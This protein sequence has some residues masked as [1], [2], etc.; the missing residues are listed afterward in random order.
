MT[1]KVNNK[2]M[3]QINDL[4]KIYI[5]KHRQRV[6]AL[7]HVNLIL[8]EKGFVFI[9]GKSGSGKSTLLN[10]IGGLDAISDGNIFANGN[11]LKEMSEAQ[12]ADYR[13]SYISFIFQDYHLID[14]LTVYE[15]VALSLNLQNVEDEIKVKNA[16]H[17]V[18]LDGY[19]NRYP[20]ELSGGEKQRVSI[21][22]A[23]VKQPKII[24]AD[25]PTGNLD[26][27]TSL[28]ILKYLKEIAKTS[29]VLIVSHNTSEIEVFAERI[30]SLE[31]GKI[32][33]D[34]S[35]NPSYIDTLEIKENIL[36][37]P[38]RALKDK[39]VT[40]LN[41][42]LQN[43]K[44]HYIKTKTNKYLPTPQIADAEIKIPLKTH[45]FKRNSFFNLLKKF[46]NHK[47]VT[48]GVSSF[49]IA[50]LFIVL[51]VCQSLTNF[52]ADK[53][54]N[55]QMNNYHQD[56]YILKKG[57]EFSQTYNLYDVSEDE[58]MFS[59]ISYKGERYPI[60]PYCLSISNNQL[61]AL[62]YY[63]STDLQDSLFVSQ[64]H[65]MIIVNEAFLADKFGTN[66]KLKLHAGSLNLHK[67]GFIITDYIADC[68]IARGNGFNS[69][70]DLINKPSFF[71]EE[72]V[73]HGYVNAII[74][75]GYHQRYS[76][77]LL[78]IKNATTIED[79]KNITRSEDF[80]SL[81]DEILSSLAIT[82]TINPNFINDEI[83]NT[84]RNFAFMQNALF[85]NRKAQTPNYLIRK[86]SYYDY[87]LKDNEIIMSV[88]WY[89]NFFGTKY[90]INNIENFSP[91]KINFK[92][93]LYSDI[94]RENILIN[95]D[96]YIVGL[97]FKVSDFFCCSEELFKEVFETQF[98]PYATYYSS[99]DNISTFLNLSKKL[100]YTILSS[101]GVSVY[102]MTYVVNM[103]SPVF[104]I[105]NI[106]LIV[107]IVMILALFT[108]KL[109]KDKIHDIGI[110]KALGTKNSKILELFLWQNLFIILS[111]LI[112]FFVGY[113]L[114]ANLCNDL[115]FTSLVNLSN[116]YF[117]FSFKVV[118]F[119]I[120]IYLFDALL[121]LGLAFISL[122]IPYLIIR[123]IKPVKIIKAKE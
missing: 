20:N 101:V 36:I 24:L 98:F 75:T 100:D 30:I 80:I 94:K 86:D 7:D 1:I 9:V 104:T 8:P 33:S 83:N 53:I 87:S 116:K 5:T 10:L 89:N 113:L 40:T 88:S 119:D 90:D 4:S 60:Y 71:L 78:D 107:G 2:D 105:I 31:K 12:L 29:L 112:L 76:A 22:R 64:T 39:E 44:L 45:H 63:P 118:S 49:V 11:S 19:E 51:G 37:I 70:Q 28:N 61:S 32:I 103:F 38:N 43:G 73:P 52:N 109:I 58:D 27:K 41:E 15:N 69:Y 82:Y 111:T 17:Q 34:I 108:V 23:I 3:I 16:L 59:K 56:S 122:F 99:T 93:Y 72:E 13:N 77:L 65:G 57:S 81:N 96:L 120:L 6:K 117:A 47:W 25:E 42:L 74:D 68:F 48:M 26:S 114:L 91:H 55:Q 102:N 92:Q 66:G 62:L 79:Y 35:I 106:C 95:K 50:L 21:A 121:A 67:N 115:I 18:D 84:I 46:A 110:L 85:D 123:K 54:I 97:S 14:A